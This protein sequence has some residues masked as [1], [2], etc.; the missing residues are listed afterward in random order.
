MSSFFTDSCIVFLSE[1]VF[2]IGGWIF[3]M[4]ELFKNYEVHHKIVIFGFSSTF[5]L[6]CIM[7]E[8]IIFEIL[9]ILSPESRLFH[10]KLGIYSILFLLVVALPFQISY[11]IVRT[12][13]VQP[14]RVIF[15]MSFVIWLLMIYLFWKIGDPFP[16]LS[17]K[18]GIL[19]IEQCISRVGVIGVTVMACLS[20][21]GAVNCP[22]TY[23]SYFVKNVT[24]QDVSQIEKRII[25]TYD[26][27]LFK[28]KRVA[29][30][31]RELHNKMN[32]MTEQTG[33]WSR[34][35]TAVMQPS[36]SQQNLTVIKREVV[37]LEEMARQL[38]LELVDLNHTVA[39]INF[40]KTFQGKYFN[41]VGYF[42]SL[43]CVWKI[44]IV[45]F[46]CFFNL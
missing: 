7:F 46:L 8:L 22:Y 41:F 32:S 4:K 26:M 24:E 14:I 1:L 21:F 25:Q 18:H 36:M 27:I 6:S 13:V 15:G 28:K 35:K 16:I 42:F 10:W 34:F 20:G 37:A 17:T 31:E 9:D 11:F 38:F 19:S 12:K 44:F 23:M 30:S 43:Y 39:R 40:S 5:S 29:I 2:F 45:I 3:F 33:I